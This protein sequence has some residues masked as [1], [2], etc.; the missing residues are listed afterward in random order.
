MKMA[1]QL[2][3]QSFF[4]PALT[5]GFH[6]AM[7]ALTDWWLSSRLITC[8]QLLLK[9]SGDSRCV[10]VILSAKTTLIKFLLPLLLLSPLAVSAAPQA[11][12]DLD[13]RAQEVV[14]RYCSKQVGIPYASDN[15]TGREWSHFKQCRKQLTDYVYN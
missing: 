13:Y 5:I 1:L 8:K 2:Q 7:F 11:F 6:K 9:W 10:I 4:T 3:V 15:F 12:S 14:D